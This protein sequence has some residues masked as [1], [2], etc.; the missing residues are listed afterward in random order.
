MNW[1]S[2]YVHVYVDEPDS[3]MLLYSD[4]NQFN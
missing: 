3:K 1:V 2:I 4:F